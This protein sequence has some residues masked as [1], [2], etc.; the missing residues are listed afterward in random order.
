MFFSGELEAQ[1]LKMKIYLSLSSLFLETPAVK[2][3]RRKKEP[4]QRALSDEVFLWS[5]DQDSCTQLLKG[6]QVSYDALYISHRK[7][8]VSSELLSTSIAKMHI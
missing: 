8:W 4:N 2:K 1:L 3:G 7:R 6:E 5:W